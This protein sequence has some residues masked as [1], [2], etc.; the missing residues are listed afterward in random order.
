M[1]I[2]QHAIALTPNPRPI[3][4]ISVIK[5]YRKHDF[6]VRDI[7]SRQVVKEAQHGQTVSVWMDKPAARRALVWIWWCSQSDNYTGPSLNKIKRNVPQSKVTGPNNS[8]MLTCSVWP[9]IWGTKYSSLKCLFACLSYQLL[10]TFLPK[11]QHPS[12]ASVCDEK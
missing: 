9:F 7:S 5:V 12:P 6:W 11:K 4:Y 8:N 3:D 2:S 1:L 10:I